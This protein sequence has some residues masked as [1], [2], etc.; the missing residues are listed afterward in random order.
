MR[1]Q[2]GRIIRSANRG[3]CARIK[4]RVRLCGFAA[5]T[6]IKECGGGV[7]GSVREDLRA[8]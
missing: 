7:W 8:S 4:F 2:V 6:Y 5:R 1:V 3:F